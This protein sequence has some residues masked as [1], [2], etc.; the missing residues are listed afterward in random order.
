MKYCNH[1]K[2]KVDDGFVAC[3]TCGGA[4]TQKAAKKQKKKSKVG[5]RIIAV[6]LPILVILTSV[7]AILLLQFYG[8][9]SGP[10]ALAALRTSAAFNEMFEGYEA[11]MAGMS[12]I[13]ELSRNKSMEVDMTMSIGQGY[14]RTQVHMGMIY[15]KPAKYAQFKITPVAAQDSSEEIYVEVFDTTAYVTL[16]QFGG[17][18]LTFDTVNIYDQWRDSALRDIMGGNNGYITPDL[19]F[20]LF[21]DEEETDQGMDQILQE[22]ISSA[23][24]Y[25]DEARTVPTSQGNLD[26]TIYD[27]ELDGELLAR[28]V[29]EY[30]DSDLG[31]L[32]ELIGF[33]AVGGRQLD[34]LVEMLGDLS[35]EAAVNA[36]GVLCGIYVTVD[37]VTYCVI[38]C[39]ENNPWERIEFG[40]IA[41][42]Q[43]TML[44]AITISRGTSTLDIRL[45]D[46]AGAT[47]YTM[48][49]DQNGTL[50]LTGPN[51]YYLTVQLGPTGDGVYLYVE[52][53][54][55]C[56][57]FQFAEAPGGYHEVTGSVV[58]LF[59]GEEEDIADFVGGLLGQ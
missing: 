40:Q 16:P 8:S 41:G 14:E 42:G 34:D 51:G 17:Q 54:D 25:E 15:D 58:D 52:S 45:L 31:A 24:I 6:L 22:F 23:G 46:G 37:E 1:C 38:L 11:P 44:S 36:D 48:T 5:L 39:G 19:S 35:I 47:V 43:Y 29:E 7:V 4:L 30:L 33:G 59:T 12:Q 28:Y 57:T 9:Q 49:L 27:V 20:D 32:Y 2:V 53:P 26:V 13:G 18:T 3:P 55:F 56:Y 10:V 50:N 21:A